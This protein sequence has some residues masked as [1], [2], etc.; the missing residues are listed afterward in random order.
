MTDRNNAAID[1]FSYESKL[2][3][4]F[5]MRFSQVFCTLTDGIETFAGNVFVF[6]L[7]IEYEISLYEGKYKYRKEL[8]FISILLPI[9][10]V[11][12]LLK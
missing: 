10:N 1:L 3:S 9:Q 2:F 7:R 6:F 11:V 5:L 8:D 4:N 12:K